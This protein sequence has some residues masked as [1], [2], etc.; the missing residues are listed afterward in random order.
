MR[1]VGSNVE[2]VDEII[3]LVAERRAAGRAADVPFL[4]LHHHAVDGADADA[5]RRSITTRPWKPRQIGKLC[6]QHRATIM[7]ATPTFLRNYLRR[8]EPEDFATLDVV[9]TGAEKLP[10]EL[11][12]AFEKRFGVRPVEGYGATELSPVVS[13]NIPPS[14]DASG[15]AG[16]FARGPWAGRCPASPPR[17]SIWTPARNWARQVGHA[18]GD[19]SERD[20]RLLRPARPDGRGD[21]RRLVRDRRRGP[22]RRRRLHPHHRPHQPLLEDRRRDGAAHPRR[23]GHPQTCCNSTRTSCGW[24]SPPCPTRRRASGWWCCT[25]ACR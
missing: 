3:H 9:F 17:W 2:A 13:A 5:Q 10:P 20:E 15:R 4:R 1:N 18:A 8:C 16:R 24:R 19:R 7:I 21:P 14:R 22:H 11:A 25:P 12:D 23:G 6:R